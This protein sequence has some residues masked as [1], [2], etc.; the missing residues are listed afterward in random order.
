MNGIEEVA[1]V[2]VESDCF[3]KSFAESY[4]SA[5][6]EGIEVCISAMF[7]EVAF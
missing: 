2:D 4:D 1:C 5:K 6:W 7:V 3:I